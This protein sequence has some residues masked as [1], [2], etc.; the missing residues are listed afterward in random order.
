MAAG[1]QACSGKS[2]AGHAMACGCS[3][4]TRVTGTECQAG[5]IMCPLLRLHTAES[6]WYVTALPAGCMTRGVC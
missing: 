1:I 6:D 3:G 2:H 4:C 5:G